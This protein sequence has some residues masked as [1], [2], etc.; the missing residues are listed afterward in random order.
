M[1]EEKIVA[2]C[3]TK[4][5]NCKAKSKELLFVLDYVFRNSSLSESILKANK[6]PVKIS[7]I[8]KENTDGVYDVRK[9]KVFLSDK[10]IK[11]VCVGNLD[12]RT[13]VNTYGH[14]KT[15]A[16][17]YLNGASTLRDDLTKEEVRSVIEKYDYEIDDHFREAYIK[18]VAYATYLRNP[19]EAIARESGH[20]FAIEALLFLLENKYLQEDIKE[21]IME[22]IELEKKNREKELMVDSLHEEIYDIFI[23]D[24][25]EEFDVIKLADIEQKK[26]DGMNP[27]TFK[28]LISTYFSSKNPQELYT[29]FKKLFFYTSERCEMISNLLVSRINEYP[30]DKEIIKKSIIDSFLSHDFDNKVYSEVL[31][32]LFNEEEIAFLY[33]EAIKQDVK[34]ANAP[35][36]SSVQNDASAMKIWD[37]MQ[38]SL[39]NC[40]KNGELKIET[41]E[42]AFVVAKQLRKFS[43]LPYDSEYCFYLSDL[44]NKIESK[45]N[46][47][48]I[49]VNK[50]H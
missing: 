14:E 15:H 9:K 20:A 45:V 17:R 4:I 7:S 23:K 42:D 10:I 6:V 34:K 47:K 40:F 36:F 33:N 48:G 44:A 41:E 29:D 16:D 26:G 21:K 46:K 25:N 39:V 5:Y 24:I 13:I 8:K 35:L 3:V 18:N 22:S 19:E 30:D 32:P 43:T 50:V 38:I 49:S 11:E 37:Y 27:Y 1:N 12:F 2:N 31:R 28:W